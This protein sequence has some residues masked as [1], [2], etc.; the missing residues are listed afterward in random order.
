MRT[1]WR[2]PFAPGRL[3]A[4]S[5]TSPAA[6]SAGERKV[7]KSALC[8]VPASLWRQLQLARCFHDKSFVRWPPHINLLYPFVE[9][10]GGS[11]AA[12]AEAAAGALADVEPFQAS[13]AGRPPP[14]VYQE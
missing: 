11:F 9:D 4:M 12:A 7:H 6:S 10:E 14:W 5:G 1:A 2:K 13:G 8:F 3:R